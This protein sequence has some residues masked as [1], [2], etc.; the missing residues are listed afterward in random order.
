MQNPGYPRARRL[1]IEMVAYVLSSVIETSLRMELFFLCVPFFSYCTHTC[2]L[3][4]V[5]GFLNLNS[6]CPK[7][8][9]TE[10]EGELRYVEV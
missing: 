8:I 4:T 5:W 6:L 1:R 10:T 3:L 2:S 9:E 7:C